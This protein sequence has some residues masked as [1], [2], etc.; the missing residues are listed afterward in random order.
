MVWAYLGNPAQSNTPL[1][2]GNTKPDLPKSKVT[3]KKKG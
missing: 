3:K 1:F 2:T